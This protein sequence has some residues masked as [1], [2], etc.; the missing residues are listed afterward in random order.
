M[1]GRMALAASLGAHTI[2]AQPHSSPPPT[3]LLPAVPADFVQ[4]ESRRNEVLGW[5]K[6][7]VRDF[8]I[9]RAA[10][11]WGELQLLAVLLFGVEDSGVVAGLR[12]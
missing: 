10:V 12:V 1:V 7:G 5:V 6:A 3:I 4:P 11:E 9:S 2:C 8:S